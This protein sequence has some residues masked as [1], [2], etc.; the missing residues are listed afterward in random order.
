MEQEK[1]ILANIYLIRDKYPISKELIQFSIL[2]KQ[3]D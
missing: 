3:P 2:K 1:K